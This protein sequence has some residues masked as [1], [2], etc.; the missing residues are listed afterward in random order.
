MNY[1]E[2]WRAE[3]PYIVQKLEASSGAVL[4]GSRTEAFLQW[5]R[6]HTLASTAET[7]PD[8]KP[9]SNFEWLENEKSA[10][11]D[12]MHILKVVKEAYFDPTVE[13]ITFCNTGHWATI[14]WFVLS[15]LAH[16]ETVKLYTGSMFDWS[17]HWHHMENTP[18]LLE[19]L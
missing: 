19:N 3:A 15:E 14:N 17:H 1:A 18:S 13:V 12:T 4:I 16:F 10:V 8:V 7:L 6:K 5:A 9:L 11:I 2:D